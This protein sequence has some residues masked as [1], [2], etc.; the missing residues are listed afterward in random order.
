MGTVRASS[1]QVLGPDA[2][3][4]LTPEEFQRDAL[5]RDAA[6]NEVGPAAATLAERNLIGSGVSKQGSPLVSG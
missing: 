4:E 1:E 6:N 3:A 2:D 5:G